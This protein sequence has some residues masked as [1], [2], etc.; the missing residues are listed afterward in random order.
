MKQLGADL[1]LKAQSLVVDAL[2]VGF[3]HRLAEFDAAD[4]AGRAHALALGPATMVVLL[5]TMQHRLRATRTR[6]LSAKIIFRRIHS[7]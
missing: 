5:L 7:T 6:E 1:A 2:D 4:G 3:D